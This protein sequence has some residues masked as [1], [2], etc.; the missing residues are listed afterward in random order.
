MKINHGR[1]NIRMAQQF[2][3]L[4]YVISSLEHMRCE[5]VAQGVWGHSL[6]DTRPVRGLSYLILEFRR[7][8][9]GSLLHPG[10]GCGDDFGRGEQPVP[11]QG[12]GQLPA[13]GFAFH[14]LGQKDAVARGFAGVFLPLFLDCTEVAAQ[15]AHNALR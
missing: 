7:V 14:L 11:C 5:G 8:D 15:L 6:G 10:P 2:L 13:S 4:P 1:P 9:M 12:S 3:E